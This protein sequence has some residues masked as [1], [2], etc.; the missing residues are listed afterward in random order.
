MKILLVEDEDA[1]FEA[2]SSFLCNSLADKKP[3]ISRCA[4]FS[5]ATKCIYEEHYDLILIDIFMPR[6]KG[7]EPTDISSEIVSHIQDSKF[8]SSTTTIA[9]SMHREAIDNHNRDFHESGIILL[10]YSETDSAWKS[11]LEI[12][13]QKV[14][15]ETT[16]DFVIM[17]ALEEERNA[18]READCILGELKTLF[19]LDCLEVSID[20][21]KGLIIRPPKMGLVDAS[22]SSSRAIERFSPR[23]ICM[24]GICAGFSGQASIG[25]L[26]ISERAWEHQAGKWSEGNNFKLTNYQSNIDDVV[27]IRLDQFSKPLEK[28][29]EMKLR[30]FIGNKLLH[31][32]IIL[33]PT[34]S[35][36]AVI[37]SAEKIAEIAGQHRKLVAL[38]M[39]IYGL[40]R[41]VELSTKKPIFFAAKTVVDLAD[42]SKGDDFHLYG[43][44]LSARFV[45]DAIR[46]LMAQ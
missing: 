17:C 24:S 22:I 26:V 28:F 16:F 25:T 3:E 33:A 45:V 4:F 15:I 35:G 19:G 7:D 37:A 38:D 2:V 8:N 11:A 32:P 44:V 10:Y 41:A 14:K 34:V 1:K 42:D 31:E 9:I 12:C 23:L 29:D 30:G 43:S 5:E 27:R 13:L 18:F 46:M 40:Y 20:N 36:S 21:L 6:R 39:E